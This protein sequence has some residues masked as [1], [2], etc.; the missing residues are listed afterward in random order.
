MGL[1]EGELVDGLADAA[2]E[3]RLAGADLVEQVLT[4]GAMF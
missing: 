3:G 2:I 1:L 4:G